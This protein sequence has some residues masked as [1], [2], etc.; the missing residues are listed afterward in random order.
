MY[1]RPQFKVLFDRLAEPRRFIQVLAG[2]RQ[3]GKTTLIGQ[4]LKELPLA[5]R[6]A[7][8]DALEARSPAWL[9]Q[10]WNI[11]RIESA[12]SKGR[13]H[14]LA[15]DEI[16]KVPDWSE[17]V[18]KLW[19]EDTRLGT[20]LKVI[21][22]GSSPLLIQSGL[23]ESLAGRFEV[24]RLSHWAYPEMRDAFGFD[25]ERYVFFGGY[26]GA[27]SLIADESRWRDYVR[28]SIIETTIMRDVLMMSRIDKPML[29]RHLLEIG[30]QRSGQVLSFNKLLGQLHDAG[31]TTTLSHYLDL[32]SAAGL[33]AGLRKYAKAP[34]RGRASSPKLHILNTALM[35]AL[36]SR[37]SG[38]VRNDPAAWG[39]WVESAVGA[40][41][42]A[43]AGGDVRVRYWR[44][45]GGE[46]D[47]V[48][49][50]GGRIAAIEVK[51]GRA[52]DGAPGL[53]L[54]LKKHPDAKS[55]LVGG[56]GL[57]VEEF[58]SVK[59]EDLI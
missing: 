5:S 42:L 51:S 9:D 4:V 47:F 44:E 41:L 57:P 24:L 13:G 33:L 40:H 29:L 28:E 36:N 54:F 20:N 12:S 6:Y 46:V 50:K 30:A 53:G 49:E 10:Q 39:R 37:D 23:A 59:V 15:I 3:S 22:L 21:I 34:F 2:P 58:F 38:E 19:D 31:N 17:R 26:P 56:D 45:N 14:V 1:K 8:G 27:A 43:H 35:S 16:Q 52:R 48:L 7:T 55:Y 11:A 25:L 18:K 32:L